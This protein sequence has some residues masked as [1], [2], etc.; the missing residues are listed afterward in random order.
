MKFIVENVLRQG[1]FS[2][3]VL[4]KI[5][6]IGYWF[7]KNSSRMGSLAVGSTAKTV[8]GPREENFGPS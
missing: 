3:Q 7:S 1:V 8:L 6:K 5:T 4:L 2:E